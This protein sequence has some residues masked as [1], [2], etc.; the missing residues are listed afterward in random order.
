MFLKKLHGVGYTL[1]MVKSMATA[2]AGSAP[3]CDSAALEAAVTSYVPEARLLSNVGAEM[4]F[5]VP[6]SSSSLF[7][8]LFSHLETQA[9]ALGV[10]S[11]GISVTTLEEVFLKVA[12][13][14][15]SEKDGA[16]GHGADKDSAAAAAAAAAPPSLT[17]SSAAS[18][19]KES[20]APYEHVSGA[21]LFRAHFFALL[22]KRLSY[23]LRDRRAVVFQLLIPIAALSAGLALRHQV[24]MATR[25]VI[26]L[27]LGYYNT[28]ITSTNAD[29]AAAGARAN[30]VPY[31]A[32]KAGVTDLVASISSAGAGVGGSF[33]GL[34]SAAGAVFV[35][36][37]GLPQLYPASAYAYPSLN[38]SSSSC[39]SLSYSDGLPT[40]ALA[41][42]DDTNALTDAWALSKWLLEHRNGSS[43]SGVDEAGASRY[44]ALSLSALERGAAP[45][46][47]F[48][49]YTALV[50]STA[51]H[52]APAAVN[53]VNSG[54]LNWLTGGAG[55]SISVENAP[56][57]FTQRQSIVVSSI[58]SFISVLFVVIAFSFVP[59]S[60]AVFVVKEREVGAK[61]QQ[62]ISGVGI[63]AYW[64]ST[65]L[66]DIV[67]YSLPCGAALVLIAAFN[68]KE[69]LGE[70]LP[71]T[72]LLFASYGTAV[73]A[74][75]YCT[76]YLFESHSSAQ[77][78]TL[79]VNLLCLVML[80]ASYVMHLI[81]ATCDTDASL[82]YLFRLVP[83]YAMG[84][85]LLQLTVL[86]ELPFLATD[87][88]RI[89]LA[90]AVQQK[91]TPYS[92]QAAGWPLLYLA[93]ETVV[94][95]LLA[96][97]IDVALSYPLVRSRLLP[98]KD[99]PIAPVDE[100]DDVVHEAERV[101]RGG[102]RDETIVVRRLRKVYAGSKIAVRDLSFGLPRGECFGF[103]GINGAGKTTT[104]KIL[105]GDVV[106]TSGGATLGGFDILRNQAEVRRLV[107]YWLVPAHAFRP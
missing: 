8:A 67:N 47:A 79:V 38:D 69:L 54:L 32:S 80:L 51:F 15:H 88:G 74:F 31:D 90:Q 105:T 24:S 70:A 22:R 44:V 49:S 76:T 36:V 46:S 100:D 99:L 59:A 30:F 93:T 82:R 98:D 20:A 27:S 77:T 37:S 18:A 50:N 53:L 5:Q 19:A 42:A 57:P 45:G 73:A 43:D 55:A 12:E 65:F 92:L 101:A 86:A 84:E 10:L 40:L 102:A 64:C 96:I 34:G 103:L 39:L 52:A 28:A 66:W 4:S 58:T 106:P 61:H 29:A 23:A 33:A 91:F 63:T 35:P 71:A 68:V 89:P 104:M 78:I 21:D 17:S 13:G 83:G 9:S 48:A 81:P 26:S 41:L 107:G 2:A 56:L 7:P 75:T 11:Y 87:C 95:F 1:T 60:F 97:A 14:S 85:G 16:K 72:A 6:L 3:A 94:Y 25:P 62:L